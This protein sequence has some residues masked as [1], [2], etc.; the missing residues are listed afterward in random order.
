MDLLMLT[1]ACI[2]AECKLVEILE[3][4]DHPLLIGEIENVT[5]NDKQPLSYFQ[6]RYHKIG[7]EIQKP[8]QEYRDKIKQLTQLF[9]KL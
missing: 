1:G 8:S 4:G 5:A 6:G 7:E 2:N 9:S 3:L